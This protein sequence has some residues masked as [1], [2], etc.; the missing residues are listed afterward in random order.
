MAGE[1]SQMC[2]PCVTARMVAPFFYEA[3]VHECLHLLRPY[4]LRHFYFF[5]PSYDLDASFPISEYSIQP[6]LIFHG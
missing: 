3:S 4:S 6:V 5:F 2:A 1:S